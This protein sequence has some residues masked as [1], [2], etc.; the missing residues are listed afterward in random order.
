MAQERKRIVMENAKLTFRD[1]AGRRYGTG[2]F[3]LALDADIALK[4]KDD[5]WNVKERIFDDP[6]EEP[7]YW[8]PVTVRWDK[9][10]PDIIMATKNNE[11]F[12]D[13]KTVGTLDNAEFDYVNLVVTP[14]SQMR[15]YLKS[16]YAM[17]Q[18]DDLMRWRRKPSDIEEDDY[19]F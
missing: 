15:A 5:G 1:F 11:T 8:L 7:S 10:P 19:P 14:S 18:E 9:F 13:E 12:L 4:L 6:N 2:A 3:G 16:M 17:V